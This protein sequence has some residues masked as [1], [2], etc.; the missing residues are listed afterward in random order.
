M[1]SAWWLL[2]KE[3]SKYLNEL[4]EGDRSEKT[5]EDYEW[6]L[7]YAFRGLHDA[8]LH[9]NPRKVGR[10]EIDYLRHE[11]MTGAESYKGH[12]IKVLRLFLKWA[13]N[14]EIANMRIG[15]RDDGV[16]KCR[17]LKDEEAMT[18]RLAANGVERMIVH[19]ELD[20]GMR[21]IEVLR[22][23]VGDFQTGRNMNTVQIHGKGRYGGKF[24]TIDWHPDTAVELDAYL[25]VRDALVL[26]AKRSNPKAD[27]PENLLIY[28]RSGQIHPYREGA[29]DEILKRLSRR[30]GIQ[31]SNHDLRRTCGRMMWRA[32]VKL[33]TIARIFGHSDTRTT[34]KYLGLD[35]EDMSDAMC[36]YAQYQKAVI[37]PKTE[38]TALEP[39]VVS[40]P[41]RI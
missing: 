39:D 17:W 12:N 14:N 36:Q 6:V 30:T 27:V 9:V 40:G 38:K 19:C 7:R 15:F 1:P 5:L 20:L 26:K 32:G 41:N 3:M 13:G 11:Y 22:L 16:R 31:F 21:R 2:G 23:K 35:H 8:K 34:M 29:V 4:R 28:V 24:R 33:E 10:K 18:V 25:S 37:F